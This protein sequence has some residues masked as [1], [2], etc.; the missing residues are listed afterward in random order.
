MVSSHPV[1]VVQK[2]LLVEPF[3]AAS[4]SRAKLKKKELSPGT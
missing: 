2:R 4:I 3:C 1:L